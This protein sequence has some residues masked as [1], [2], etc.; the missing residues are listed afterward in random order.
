MFGQYSYLEIGGILI[1]LIIIIPT[2]YILI[3]YLLFRVVP[4]LL[5]T[6]MVLAFLFSFYFIFGE[7]SYG[8]FALIWLT[9][10]IS[11]F[12]RKLLIKP[13]IV[14]IVK[15]MG[16]GTYPQIAERAGRSVEDTELIIQ[17]LIAAGKLETIP[18]KEGLAVKVKGSDVKGDNFTSTSIEIQLD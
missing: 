4:F 17:D 14:Y 12:M 10:F 16:M 1:G 18:T 5:Q 8:A 13:G 3:K 9:I 11:F 7:T 15:K 6:Y 2:T